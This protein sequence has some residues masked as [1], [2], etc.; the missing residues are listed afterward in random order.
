VVPRLGL[1]ALGLGL[2]LAIVVAAGSR[3][4]A[5]S[6]SV[7]GCQLLP[8][9][10]VW[11]ARIDGLPVHPRSADWVR[12]IGAGTGLHPDF[13]SGLYAGAPIGIPYTTVPG[14]Q[15]EVSVTFDYADESDPGPYRIPPDAPVEGGADSHVIVVERDRCVLAELFA[16]EQLSATSWH[17]GSGAIFDLGSNA[18]RPT[19]WT[20]ADAAGLPI[21]AGLARYEEVAA[22]EITHALR[23]TAP[24]TQRSYLWPARHY[25]ST[26]TDPSLPPMGARFRLKSSFNP[27]AY[28]TQVR[29]IL[30]ALQRY[31]MFLADNGSAWFISGAPSDSWDNDALHRLQEVLGTSFEVVDESSLI[32]DSSSGQVRAAPPPLGTPAPISTPTPT[33]TRTS[34]PRPTSTPTPTHS[35][36]PTCSPRPSVEVAVAASGPDRLQVTITA[37]ASAGAPNNT[38]HALRFG[39]ATNALIDI[40]ATTGGSGDFTAN[41]PSAPQQVT[42]TIRRAIAGQATTVPLV[43]VDDCGDWPTFVGAGQGAL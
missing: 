34:T 14:S 41:L 2:A 37:E 11:N 32:V 39:A 10:N 43:V 21:L 36:R 24:R 4:T 35:P 25:A 23:F 22:G 12:T 8:S 40:G 18:L 19:G 30:V 17:A 6:G 20:S 5:A 3:P 26:D 31:G 28:P 7:S 1:W 29:V 13:G 42:F 9:D 27:S 33:P 38:L 16:A 15:P